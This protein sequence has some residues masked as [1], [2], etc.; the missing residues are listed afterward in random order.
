MYRKPRGKNDT[1]LHRIKE[2]E[3]E[4]W[5]AYLIINIIIM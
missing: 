5:N 3:R 1:Q 2:R 4:R